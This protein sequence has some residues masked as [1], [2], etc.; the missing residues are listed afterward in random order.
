MSKSD[1]F[2]ERPLMNAAGTLGFAPD[3][4]GPV[5]LSAFGAFITNPISRKPRKPARGVRFL[6]YHGG[7]LLHTGLPNPGLSATIRRYSERWA[8]SSIPVI[9][10]LLAQEPN[11]LA[12]MIERLEMAEGIMGV[13]VGLPPDCD[14]DLAAKMAQ[15]TL[16]EL[17]VILRVNLD[18]SRDILEAIVETGVNAISL[19]APRGTLLD[20]H[21][22]PVS[23][24]LYGPGVFPLAL[25]ALKK[26]REYKIPIIGSG[27]VYGQEEAQAMLA[28]GAVAL[29][30]DASL[31]LGNNLNLTQA[32]GLES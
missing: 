4:K 25:S 22:I 29:Q 1:L 6:R 8:R 23:G 21:G 26:F 13:E 18:V 30:L 32:E 15:A 28:A 20:E 14:P 24:R 9:L 7:F 12:A 11:E 19:G 2:F 3:P 10:H 31:W 16:G 27:G 17:P 5:D